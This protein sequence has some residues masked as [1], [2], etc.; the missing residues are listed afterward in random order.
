MALS[1]DSLQAVIQSKYLPKLY[2][3]IFREDRYLTRRLVEKAKEFTGRE[4]VVPLEYAKSAN[5]EF[6]RKMDTFVLGT[7]DPFTAGVSSPRMLTGHLTIPYEEELMMNS[8]QAIDNILTAKIKN[9]QSSIEYT[10]GTNLYSRT[11]NGDS[12]ANAHKWYNLS[13]VCS[14]SSTFEG[15]AVADMASWAANVID[16]DGSSYSDDPSVEDNLLDPNSDVYIIKLIQQALALGKH[17]G[18]DKVIVCPQY[19]YNLIES[20]LDPRKQGSKMSEKA[21][22]YG[23]ELIHINGVPVMPDDDMVAQQTGDTDGYIYVLNL[24]YLYMYFNKNAK[25][26]AGKWLEPTNQNSKTMKVHTYGNMCVSNRS[27]QTVITDIRSPKSYINS[28]VY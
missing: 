18:G 14:S 2:D 15:I 28:N 6:T 17:R 25:F 22:K 20:I 5:V 4:I 19:I 9:L 16:A 21:G 24:D 10:V 26:K 12:G 7:V 8:A 3:N 1:Y 27:A 13:D 11:A 23:F